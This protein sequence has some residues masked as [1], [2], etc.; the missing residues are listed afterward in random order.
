MMSSS[1]ILRRSA[2]LSS[3]A[4]R[5]I[6][7]LQ[8]APTPLYNRALNDNFPNKNRP[9]NRFSVIRTFSSKETVTITYCDPEGGEHPVEAEIGKNLLDVA[10]DN[11][12]ELE[13]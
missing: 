10:H 4:I 3:S 9:D 8:E 6:R 7:R 11:N 2:L 12:I 1:M 13:G 5:C